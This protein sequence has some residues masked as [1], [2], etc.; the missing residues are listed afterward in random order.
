MPRTA[1]RILL[2]SITFHTYLDPSIMPDPML[3]RP[4]PSCCFCFK[5]SVYELM[6][7]NTVQKCE[8]NQTRVQIMSTALQLNYFL[9]LV[10]AQLTKCCFTEKIK[11]IIQY[12][13]RR[14][15][16]VVHILNY[17][18]LYYILL[19]RIQILIFGYMFL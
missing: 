17:L 9:L 19:Y 12:M 8:R 14:I 15:C 16:V 3:L 11:N 7:L 5:G 2:H 1:R 13:V 4:D 10:C 18:D 6:C